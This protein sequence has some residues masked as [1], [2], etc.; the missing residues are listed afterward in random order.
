M[1]ARYGIFIAAGLAALLILQAAKADEFTSSSFKILEP[2]VVS[3]P[4]VQKISLAA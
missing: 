4:C 1:K 2:V 3:I